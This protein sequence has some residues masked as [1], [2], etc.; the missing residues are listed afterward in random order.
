MRLLFRRFGLWLRFPYRLGLR[1]ARQ[2]GKQLLHIADALERAGIGLLLR[3]SPGKQ[4]VIPLQGIAQDLIA[5]IARLL[6]V[7]CARKAAQHLLP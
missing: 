1:S 5:Q 7:R 4:I 3:F 6:R 2:A